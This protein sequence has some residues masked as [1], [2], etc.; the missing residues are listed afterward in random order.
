MARKQTLFYADAVNL[1]RTIYRT[2]DY[3]YRDDFN[4]ELIILRKPEHLISVEIKSEKEVEKLST[5]SSGTTFKELR[6]KINSLSC[7]TSR[8]DGKHKGW[9]AILAQ[10]WDYMQNGLPA[11][12]ERN[13]FSIKE[14]ILILPYDKK[15]ELNNALC[16]LHTYC[17]TIQTPVPTVLD[18]PA[19][20]MS[21][22]IYTH[23]HLDSFFDEVQ[24]I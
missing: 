20:N 21:I 24:Q 8:G 17:S 7:F 2:N 15:G 3:I 13:I 10:C 12:I 9:I 6:E 11:D 5:Q 1:L 16:K 18:Y 23:A 22:L 4:G 14:D 19:D